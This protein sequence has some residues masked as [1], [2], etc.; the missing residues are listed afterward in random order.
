MQLRPAF[1][2]DAVK[3]GDFV[4]GRYEVRAN[5]WVVDLDTDLDTMPAWGRLCLHSAT[6]EMMVAVLGWKLH[7]PRLV[8]RVFRQGEQ[9]RALRAENASLRAALG[10][11]VGAVDVAETP[12]SDDEVAPV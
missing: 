1:P 9:M 11:L 2:V 3:G 8:G 4:T 6:V 7:D 5:E 10:A 12:V